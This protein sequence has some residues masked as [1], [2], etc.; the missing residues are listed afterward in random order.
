[1]TYS[2]PLLLVSPAFRVFQAFQERLAFPDLA[3]RAFQAVRDSLA[4]QGTAA[5]L[6]SQAFQGGDLSAGNLVGSALF[7]DGAGIVTGKQIGR[8]HV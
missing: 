6:V 5:F 7:G 2:N 1:M 4:S 3:F 8:A